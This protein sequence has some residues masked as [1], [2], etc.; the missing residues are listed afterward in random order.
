MPKGLPD[1]IL[2]FSIDM[3]DAALKR[4][5]LSLE[6]S[7]VFSRWSYVEF[8]V[9]ALTAVLFGN[10]TALSFL[11]RIKSQQQK[12]DAI[13]SEALAQISHAETRELVRPVF[14][15]LDRAA[16]PRNKLAHCLWGTIPELPDALLLSEPKQ[17]IRATRLLLKTQGKR[18]TIS[19]TEGHSDFQHRFNGNEDIASEIYNLMRG[20]VEVWTHEDFNTPLLLL[21][22]ATA[23]ITA[24]TTAVSTSHD[25]IGA[26]NARMQVLES[27][28]RVDALDG[29]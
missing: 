23:A 2:S 9:A 5:L 14:Q 22:N 8:S 27:L 29:N 20:S 3:T 18:E 13:K 25:N 10:E 19:E 12:M 26:I 16:K 4:P 6:A 15:L 24:L 7:R 28:K 17:M 11:D 21:D 1:E